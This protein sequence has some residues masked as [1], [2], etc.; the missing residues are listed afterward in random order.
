M[1]LCGVVK[2]KSCVELLEPVVCSGR[3]SATEDGI[4]FLI[5]FS[6]DW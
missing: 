1:N 2:L 4:V 5:P 3:S 6:H